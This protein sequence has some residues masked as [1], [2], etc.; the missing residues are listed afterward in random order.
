[1]SLTSIAEAFADA[2]IS[3]RPIGLA[4]IVVGI[5][6][7]VSG[8]E[9]ISIMFLV[10]EPGK[11]AFPYGFW[12]IH[13]AEPAIAP[14][15]I[16]WLLFAVLFSVGIGTRLSG[17]GLTATIGFFLSTDQRLY[18]NHFYL[19]ALTVLFLTLA[20]S[21]AAR[22]IDSRRGGGSPTVPAW[23][24]LLLKIQ[25]TIVYL[26]AALSKINTDYLSGEIV[27]RFFRFDHIPLLSSA[28][29][30]ST[31][32]AILATLAIVTE[33]FL[34]AALWS[35]RWRKAGLATASLFHGSLVIIMNGG[36]LFA[37]TVFSCL[38][39]CLYTLCSA[40]PLTAF[41]NV[42]KPLPTLTTPTTWADQPQ[43]LNPAAD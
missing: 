7:I 10:F 29:P 1:M 40:F 35:T 20:D 3:S 25:L 16:A 33:L 30:A 38:M 21:G 43:S 24:L 18:S 4:R 15:G 5:V 13:L 22:S 23:P 17:I 41:S 42:L 36:N 12:S 26:F 2:R 14:I 32:F 8:L 34:T 37:L 6:A 11:V 31:L 19:L 27:S 9:A 28:I 39:I